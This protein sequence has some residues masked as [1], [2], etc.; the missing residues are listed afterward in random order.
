MGKERL[1]FSQRHGFEEVR[2]AL[3]LEGMDDALSNALWNALDAALWT[4]LGLRSRAPLSDHAQRFAEL[5]WDQFLKRATDEIPPVGVSLRSELRAWWFSAVWHRRYSLLE[6]ILSLRIPSELA[7][8]WRQ[9]D[10]RLDDALEREGAG[11]RIVDGLCTPVTSPEEVDAVREAL[12]SESFSGAR[13]HLRT[14]LVHFANREEPD[15]RNS[16]K[17]S[18]SAVESAACEIVGKEKATLK[19][20]LAILRSKRDLHPALAKG[21]ESIY[22]YTSDG[23][24]IRHG[25]QERP[26]LTADDARF[27]L[28]ACSAFVNYLK[29]HKR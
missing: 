9:L 18:I 23:D 25:M 3:Q 28:V 10:R 6:W 7:P 4:R 22:G 8:V 19:E 11:Y 29:S 21:F 13:Q 2:V 5:C 27:F 12:A 14:A 16:I 20:A 1:T 26:E 15:Y 17:E 24:G